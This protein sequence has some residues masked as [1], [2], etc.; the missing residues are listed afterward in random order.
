MLRK[1]YVISKQILEQQNRD[2]DLVGQPSEKRADTDAS[3]DRVGDGLDCDWDRETVGYPQSAELLWRT[4][5]GG[6]VFK[7]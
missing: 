6:P 2:M 4:D 3:C 7:V 1:L 5:F